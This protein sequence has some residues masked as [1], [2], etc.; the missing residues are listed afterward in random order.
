[1]TQR[2]LWSLPMLVILACTPPLPER[3]TEGAPCEFCRMAISDARFG[4]A[5]RLETGNVKLF[6]AIECLVDFL[7]ANDSTTVSEILVS[8]YRDAR[9]VPAH[10]ATFLYGGTIRSPMGRQ[11]VAV[12]SAAAADDLANQFGASRARWADIRSLPA[13]QPV[14]SP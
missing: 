12:A 1:M 6:D 7:A 9:L 8:D 11:V 2:A 3:V 13:R 5:V 14:H 10:G 4:G